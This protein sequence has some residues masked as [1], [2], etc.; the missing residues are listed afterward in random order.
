M[1]LTRRTRAEIATRCRRRARRR[2]A[3]TVALTFSPLAT[4]P[5]VKPSHWLPV[6]ACETARVHLYIW[7]VTAYRLAMLAFSPVASAA[8]AAAVAGAD[9]VP[10]AW[11]ADV[12]RDE[13]R[14]RVSLESAERAG[15]ITAA[16][17]AER[18]AAS[19]ARVRIEIDAASNHAWA[20]GV[21]AV[22]VL[23]AG[24]A[25]DAATLNASEA[26]YVRPLES[27]GGGYVAGRG[28]VA[29]VAF[30]RIADAVAY[31]AGAARRVTLPG[32]AM[33]PIAPSHGADAPSLPSIAAAFAA[34]N[35]RLRA[36][37]DRAAASV[38]ARIASMRAM[39]DA[40]LAR[41]Y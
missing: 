9:V 12:V 10:F 35:E 38:F 36:S 6:L 24:N 21:R 17:A 26:A 18:L 31:A 11:I 37:G 20:H 23:E 32:E 16:D 15:T 33:P 40:E 8:H 1:R 29:S 13:T 2:H 3:L 39:I 5:H 4:R 7:S 14:Y 34:E 28:D 30:D 41:E 19:A 27:I 25:A 22:V